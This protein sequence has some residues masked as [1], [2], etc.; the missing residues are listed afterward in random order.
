MGS[1]NPQEPGRWVASKVYGLTGEVMLNFGPLPVPLAFIVLGFM[2]GRVKRCLLTWDS[3]DIRLILVP[4]MVN[5]CFVVLISDLDNDI[6][7]LLKNA[8][9]PILLICLIHKKTVLEPPNTNLPE[10][11]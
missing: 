9:F 1:Y 5:F 7:F 8:G 4:V 6:F 2:V 3:K 10:L 11:P